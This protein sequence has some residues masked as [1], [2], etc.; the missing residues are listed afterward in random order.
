[1]KVLF[2]TLILAVSLPVFHG[3]TTPPQTQE[4]V[5]YNTFNDTWT[6]AHSAYQAHCEAVVQGKVSAE[7]EAAVDASWNRFRRVFT[8]ALKASN[9]DWSA[10]TTEGLNLAEAEL[11]A[12]IRGGNL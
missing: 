2:L 1:M 8:A 7:T 11:L 12:L 6:V 3:C 9:N 4:A 10:L 5:W